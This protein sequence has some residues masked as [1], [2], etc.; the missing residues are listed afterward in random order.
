MSDGRHDVITSS[1]GSGDGSSLWSV[2]S[3]KNDL[4]ENE[5]TFGSS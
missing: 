4:E 3:S 2:I 1:N 5:R